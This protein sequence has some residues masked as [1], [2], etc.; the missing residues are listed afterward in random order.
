MACEPYPSMLV[1]FC[2]GGHSGSGTNVVKRVG[3]A[4]KHLSVVD[5]VSAITT[6]RGFKFGYSNSLPHDPKNTLDHLVLKRSLLFD[7]EMIDAQVAR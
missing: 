7:I 5:L 3:K 1:P 4:Q 6:Y 2:L